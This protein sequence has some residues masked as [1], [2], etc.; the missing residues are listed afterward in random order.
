M[1]EE[2]IYNEEFY[3]L[4]IINSICSN[5][6]Y[7]RGCREENKIGKCG[8]CKLIMNLRHRYI[9]LDKKYQSLYDRHLKQVE[10]LVNEREDLKIALSNYLNLHPK[11]HKKKIELT[12]F[13]YDFIKLYSNMQNYKFHKIYTLMYLKDK[14]HFKGIEDI[15][16]TLKEIIANCTVKDNELEELKKMEAK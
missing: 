7:E 1:N 11:E 2:F 13:E 12:Q 4:F 10:K 6:C 15:S 16:M 5:C 9:E 8:N 3:D 14:K